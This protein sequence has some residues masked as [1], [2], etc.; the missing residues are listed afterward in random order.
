[1]YTCFIAQVL[2]LLITWALKRH[3]MHLDSIT[4]HCWFIFSLAD[5]SACVSKVSSQWWITIFITNIGFQESSIRVLGTFWY[6]HISLE[7]TSLNET[8]LLQICKLFSNFLNIIRHVHS[9]KVNIKWAQKSKLICINIKQYKRYS[10]FFKYHITAKFASLFHFDIR[11]VMTFVGYNKKIV[12][13]NTIN[14][15][16]I[17][18]ITWYTFPFDRED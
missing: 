3:W 13:Y 2:S 8:F 11:C 7:L 10:S 6:Y 14:H 4:C 12:I 9:Q 17:Q 16:V 5:D 18:I 15:Y 1:M